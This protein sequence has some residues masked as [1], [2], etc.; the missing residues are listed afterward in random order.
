MEHQS[1]VLAMPA[2]HQQT[3]ILGGE[4]TADSAIANLVTYYNQ[5]GLKTQYS[6]QGNS[7]PEK[8]L[9]KIRKSA[10]QCATEYGYILFA[11]IE[12]FPTFISLTENLLESGGAH[13]RA[14]EVLVNL[15]EAGERHFSTF[16]HPAWIFESHYTSYPLVGREGEYIVKIETERKVAFSSDEVKRVY[17]VA[18]K[19]N[20][21]RFAVRIPFEDLVALDEI[22]RNLP[23]NSV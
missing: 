15:R 22:V 10:I 2:H 16:K 21:W 14:G 3:P 4:T 8:T 7:I 18:V 20:Y 9:K 12:K 23:Q 5:N 19:Q 13:P 6:C 17:D 1:T 11:E